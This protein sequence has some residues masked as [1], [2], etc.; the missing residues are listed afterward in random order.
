MAKSAWGDSMNLTGFSKIAE[1]F[2][3]PGSTYFYKSKW[4][5]GNVEVLGSSMDG[6]EVEIK[7]GGFNK[8]LTKYRP[9]Q[10]MNI[11]IGEGKFYEVKE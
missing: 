1:E 4:G 6:T 10:V 5:E 9:G 8:P 11:G 7:D 3:K 2:L